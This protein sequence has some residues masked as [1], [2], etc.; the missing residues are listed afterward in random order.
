MTS[1]VLL[2]DERTARSTVIDLTHPYW[3]SVVETALTGLAE[4]RG[5]GH[6]LVQAWYEGQ[7]APQLD[8]NVVD[9]VQDTSSVLH[10]QDRYRR[11]LLVGFPVFVPE[12][13]PAGFRVTSNDSAYAGSLVELISRAPGIHYRF[14]EA[15]QGRRRMLELDDEWVDSDFGLPWADSDCHMLVEA[16]Y[17]LARLGASLERTA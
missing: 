4:G 16:S 17:V 5:E 10:P 15:W 9:L 14:R 12:A 7:R 6:R 1:V 8:G 11:R 13:F 2:E 3:G